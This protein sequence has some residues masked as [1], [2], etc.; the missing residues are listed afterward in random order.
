MLNNIE[1]S[2]ELLSEVL[3]EYIDAVKLDG[4]EIIYAFRVSS[5]G[6]TP[7]EY[8][9]DEGS[10]NIYEL[11]HKC[12]EW[13]EE[14]LPD[15]F[16]SSGMGYKDNEWIAFSNNS[17]YTNCLFYA[18]TEPEAIFKACEWILIKVKKVYTNTT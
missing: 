15:V 8:T 14:V 7:H 4:N 13:A 2:K 18:D 9:H 17:D 16:L 10:I 5:C 6:M 3:E 11:E 1:I 12:K